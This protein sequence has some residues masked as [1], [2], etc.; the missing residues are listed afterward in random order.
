M[1][2]IT[3]H[4]DDDLVVKVEGCLAGPC[5]PA[6]DACWHEAIVAGLGLR[7]DLTDV[8]HVDHDGRALMARMYH[9]GTRFVARGCAMRELV[10]E[11]ADPG[12]HAR[13]PRVGLDPGP[14]ARPPRV[15]PDPAADRE[16]S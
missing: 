11:I 9:A 3:S 1:F 4:I 2:R 15:G 6:L 7:V 12:P 5:V 14:H 10:R 13:P 16:R 8:C